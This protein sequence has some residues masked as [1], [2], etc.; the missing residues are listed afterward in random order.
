MADEAAAK[1]FGSYVRDVL[2]LKECTDDEAYRV[3]TLR[4]VLSQIIDFDGATGDAMGTSTDRIIRLFLQ[5]QESGATGEDRL[6]RAAHFASG[7][8]RAITASLHSNI[9]RDHEVLPIRSAR[10]FDSESMLWLSRKPGATIREKLCEK[11]TVLAVRRRRSYD[12][13]ENRLLKEY[14]ILLRRLLN[15]H[16]GLLGEDSGTQR[17]A[18]DLRL[19]LDGAEAEEIGRQAGIMHTDWGLGAAQLLVL[20]LAPNKI[21][22]FARQKLPQDMAFIPNITLHR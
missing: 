16:R 3:V 13:V 10:E 4:G 1:R 2:G 7:A 21:G 12:T 20:L 9:L 18:Q 22:A 15:R 5:A 17:I 8:F 19:W 11:Q 6:L 14:A